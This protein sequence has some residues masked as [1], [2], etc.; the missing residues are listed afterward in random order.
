MLKAKLTAALESD[1]HALTR[2]FF[3]PCSTCISIAQFDRGVIENVGARQEG[4]AS[5]EASS[6]AWRLAPCRPG[7]A[8]E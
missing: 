3:M 4:T 1:S 7:T 5:P 8:P 6:I 2:C